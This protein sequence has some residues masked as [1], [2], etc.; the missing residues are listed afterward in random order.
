MTGFLLESAT[1]IRRLLARR[2]LSAREVVEATLRRVEEK[3]GE[4]NAVVT[5]DPL[6]LDEA[7]ALDERLAPRRAG[8][9]AS[10][11]AGRHQGRDAGGRAAHH[12][13]LTALR[14]SRAGRGRRG[15][16]PPARGRRDRPGQ[17]QHSR[18]RDRGQHLERGVRSHPQPVEP[19]AQ[20]RRLD[21]RRRRRARDRD[22]RA[23]RGHRPRWLAAHTRGVLRRR[24]SAPVARAGADLARRLSVGHAAGDRSD[25]APRRRRG[26][27]AAGD[28]GAELARA[29]RAAD[30]GPRL[31]GGGG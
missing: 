22:D 18:V 4:I 16:A 15:G 1:A 8:G 11:P 27:G 3:N 31:R 20:R 25:R 5:L 19:G 17:D 10:R 30:R 13:R 24:R 12:L 21:R 7:A 14:R 6:A 26:A 2:E 29:A 9:S 23:G 28:G